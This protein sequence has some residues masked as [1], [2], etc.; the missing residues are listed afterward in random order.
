MLFGAWTDC[1]MGLYLSL[2]YDS[3]VYSCFL[4]IYMTKIS[5][6]RDAADG[7]E[8]SVKRKNT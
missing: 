2:I 7:Y 8:P 3:I 4:Y 5:E 1:F 6:R